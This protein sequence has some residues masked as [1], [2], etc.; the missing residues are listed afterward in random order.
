MHLHSH[1]ADSA[2][3][4]QSTHE[5][6]HRHGLARGS[7][8][9]GLIHG[10]AGSA[11]LLLLARETPGLGLG[12]IGMVLVFGIGSII[13]MALVAQVVAVPIRSANARPGVIL[14]AIQGAAAL[15]A[16]TLGLT[17]VYG[18]AR[19]VLFA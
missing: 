11:A 14:A 5:H 4:A 18:A 7:F 16:V 12:V 2:P 3:H 9:V 17:L 13:G 10:T 19:A 8:A 6:T 15:F 1:A